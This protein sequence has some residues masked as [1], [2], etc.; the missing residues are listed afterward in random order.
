MIHRGGG[1]GMKGREGKVGRGRGR[2]KEVEG[3]RGGE[4][5]KMEQGEM[6]GRRRQEG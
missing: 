5:G 1:R 6:G 4:D 2:E 3:D